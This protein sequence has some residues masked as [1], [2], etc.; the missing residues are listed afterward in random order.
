MPATIAAA[1]ATLFLMVA[2][3][4]LRRFRWF[5]VPAMVS[6]MLFDLAMPFYLYLHRDWYERLVTGGEIL[7]FLIWMHVGLLMTLYGLYVVQ[8]KSG[9]Q[10]I[11]RV[12]Q[13]RADHRVQGWGILVVRTLVVVTGALL[14]EAE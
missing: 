14:Y 9:R 7:S 10:L 1:F 12:A 8:V 5:H 6:I 4:Y 13:A 11:G 3:V 2:A